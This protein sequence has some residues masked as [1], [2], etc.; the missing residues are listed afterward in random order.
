MVL[1]MAEDDGVKMPSFFGYIL[2][3]TIPFLLPAFFLTTWL[4]F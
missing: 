3:Y 2:L 4:F 1:A